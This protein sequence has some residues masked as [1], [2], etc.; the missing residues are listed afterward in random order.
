M[1]EGVDVSH[2]QSV[3]SVG[4]VSFRRHAR[5]EVDAHLVHVRGYSKRISK[6]A[7]CNERRVSRL[8]ALKF[9]HEFL[10]AHGL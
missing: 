10:K 3:V 5:T 7:T 4:G 1:Q 9:K 6:S 2:E 8:A